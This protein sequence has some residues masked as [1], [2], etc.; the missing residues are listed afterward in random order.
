MSGDFRSFI[1]RVADGMSGTVY[2][3]RL[4]D[5]A[6]AVVNELVSVGYGMQAAVEALQKTD[7]SL[8]G[9]CDLLLADQRKKEKEEKREEKGKE[10]Q[11][12]PDNGSVSSASSASG[13]QHTN[14]SANNA[15]EVPV[16]LV[17]NRSIDDFNEQMVHMLDEIERRVEQLRETAGLLEQEKESIV[18]MLSNFNLNTE[19]MRLGAGDREDIN[20]TANRLMARTRAVEVLVGTPRNNEQQQ[21]LVQVNTLIEGMI[22]KMSD[23]LTNSKD[24]CRRMLN[25]CSPEETGPIDQRFQAQ[26]IECTADDQKKIRRKLAQI[27]TQIERAERTCMP[28]W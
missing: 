4:T 3:S 14:M 27:I 23:D 26:V 13:S 28:Q 1:D 19:L 18:D 25:A 5:K 22:N 12:K 21:A 6:Q 7:F 8:D 20:A 17:R 24:Q 9:A 16:R 15:R 11:I 2:G 10:E